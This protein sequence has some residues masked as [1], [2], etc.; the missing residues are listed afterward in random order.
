MLGWEESHHCNYPRSSDIKKILIEKRAKEPKGLKITTLSQLFLDQWHK[1][2]IS[3]SIQA[4][5]SWPSYY[6][7]PSGQPSTAASR[8]KLL[9]CKVNCVLARISWQLIE[10]E[11]LHPYL[12]CHSRALLLMHNIDREEMENLKR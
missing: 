8:L 9:V 3:A 7:N 6:F 1:L 10:P 11:H 12:H 5:A 4:I 2:T